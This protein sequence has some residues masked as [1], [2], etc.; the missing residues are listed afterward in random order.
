M[1]DEENNTQPQDAPQEKSTNELLQQLIDER[2]QDRAELKQ[3][4]EE[5]ERHRSTPRPVPSIV[6]SPEEAMAARMQEIEQHEFYCPG[7]GMLYD[8]PQKCQGRGEAPHPAIEVVSTDE[9][10][11]GDESK[12][13]AAPGVN[14]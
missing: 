13:T 6:L 11:S 9:L 4:R 10:K 8:Y 3:M 12:H 14:P 5:L 7:C 1:A 2:A